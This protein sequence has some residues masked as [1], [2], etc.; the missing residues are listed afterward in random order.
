MDSLPFYVRISRKKVTGSIIGCCLL[1]VFL[2]WA[3]WLGSGKGFREDSCNAQAALFIPLGLVALI[4]MTIARVR[5]LFR[6]E[7]LMVL[8]QKG[9]QATGKY[10]DIMG[11]I[12]WTELR[13]CADF[14]KGWQNGKELFL[15]VKD[16]YPYM[17]RITDPKQQRRFS[18][19]SI[20]HGNALLWID[21]TY[22][23]QD[24]VGLKTKIY[25]LI[26]DKQT[27]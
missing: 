6:K 25:Q 20:K 13:G 17:G 22:A 27:Q 26:A 2:L 18:K 12:P 9:L 14:N 19:Q 3:L 24:I 15:F 10:G 7:P 16:L 8:D 21:M 1:I 4:W 11:I 5:L 23:D